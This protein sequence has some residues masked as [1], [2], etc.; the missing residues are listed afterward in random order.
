MGETRTENLR[1]Y[2]AWAEAFTIFERYLPNEKWA[3]VAG[4]HDVVYA[5]PNPETVSD[6]D[7]ARLDQLGWIPSEFDCFQKFT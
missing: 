1:S 2:A 6:E 5:G 3:Q 4:E 7:R